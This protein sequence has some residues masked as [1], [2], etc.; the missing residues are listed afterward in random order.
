VDTGTTRWTIAALAL[1]V[2]LVLGVGAVLVTEAEAQTSH[3]IVF[4]RDGDLWL[5]DAGGGDQRR[6]TSG[7]AIDAHPSWSPDGRRIVFLRLSSG[8]DPRWS[9]SRILT[10]RPSGRDLK[11]FTPRYKGRRLTKGRFLRPFW[12]PDGKTL[13]V[14]YRPSRAKSRVLLV[15]TRT[16]KARA[17][18][19]TYPDSGSYTALGWRRRHGE[20]LVRY[21]GVDNSILWRY[22]LSAKR[23]RTLGRR[24]YIQTDAAWTFSGTRLAVC[25]DRWDSDY[26]SLV[27]ARVAVADAKARPTRIVASIPYPDWPEGFSHPSWSADGRWLAYAQTDYWGDGDVYVC[28]AD[29]GSPRLLIDDAGQPA[30]S[31][32]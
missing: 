4:V 32:R 20:L 21:D 30:W 14:T 16:R 17:V 15:G 19:L 8:T 29:S 25:I 26:Q 18:L 5:A 24:G 1:G 9:P 23:L 11:T 10:I 2:L 27:D 12:S 3:S 6:L 28:G 22:S 31:P 7:T 13:V